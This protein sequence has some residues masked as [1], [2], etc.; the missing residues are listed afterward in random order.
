MSAGT[1]ITD[2]AE[3]LL[4]LLGAVSATDAVAGTLVQESGN[5]VSPARPD[6]KSTRLNS[7]H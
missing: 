6:R 5:K 1:A 3:K 2:N 7:S 4:G